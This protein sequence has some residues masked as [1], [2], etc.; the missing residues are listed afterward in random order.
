MSFIKTLLSCD[1]NDFLSVH[2]PINYM[3][4]SYVFEHICNLETSKLLSFMSELG[5]INSQKHI[6]DKLQ[7]GMN[8]IQS[9]MYIVIVCIK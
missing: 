2:I 1:E 5:E 7:N 3:K 8:Q 6:S 4:N 9:T